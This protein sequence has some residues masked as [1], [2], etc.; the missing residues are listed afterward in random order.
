M[1]EFQ[2][3][4]L[5]E[6][7]KD[8]EV[9]V[10][11][12]LDLGV[13]RGVTVND[14]IVDII[15]TPTYS[16]CPAMQVIEDDIVSLLK[17]NGVEKINVEMVLSP[18]WTTDWITEKGKQQLKEFGIAPPEKTSVDKTSITGDAKFIACP[19][20]NSKNT[21]MISQ[22]G[23]TACKALYKCLDCLEPFDYFKC[24]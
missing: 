4:E 17:E 7:V 9:P 10:L 23:S 16:G 8:P 6:E 20:C 3:R 1:N 22:F 15:L 13:V 12:I 14:N 18:A 11:S 2:I 24:L 19:Q 5:L 21:E